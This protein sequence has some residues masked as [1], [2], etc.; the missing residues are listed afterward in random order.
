VLPLELD[1]TDRAASTKLRPRPR[2]EPVTNQVLLMLP[3]RSFGGAGGGGRSLP[4]AALS[5]GVPL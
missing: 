3:F 5:A 1:V 2:D 4:T